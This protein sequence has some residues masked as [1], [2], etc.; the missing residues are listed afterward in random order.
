MEVWMCGIIN[1]LNFEIL[2]T[3]LC[4]MQQLGSG[5]ASK[6]YIQT[7]PNGQ[8]EIVK[9]ISKQHNTKFDEL[10]SKLSNCT[11]IINPESITSSKTHHILKRPYIHTNLYDR[12]STRPFLDADEKLWISY[13]LIYAMS[14]VHELDVIHGDLKLENILV[15]SW[16]WVLISDFA[17]FK[18]CL[19]PDDDPYTFSQLFDTAFR[20]CCNVAPER[21][22]DF[23]DL[24]NST[25][26]QQMDIFSIGCIL[27]E[28]H[29]EQPLFSYSQLILYKN[30]NYDPLPLL[31]SLSIELKSM[32]ANMISLDP[33]NRNTLQ[34]VLLKYKTTFPN[35]FYT[36]F[37]SYCDSLNQ[38]D[39]HH[40]LNWS[41]DYP[42]ILDQLLVGN[43]LPWLGDIKIVKLFTDVDQIVF[44]DEVDLQLKSHLYANLLLSWIRNCTTKYA[45]T[46]SLLLVDKLLPFL[47]NSFKLKRLLPFYVYFLKHPNSYFNALS[48]HFLSNALSVDAI[49]PNEANLFLSYL[50]NPIS[51]L[52]K[53]GTD[54][55]KAMLSKSLGKLAK[56][57]RDHIDMIDDQLFTLDAHFSFDASLSDLHEAFQDIFLNLITHVRYN[58]K[59]AL[60][61]YSFSSLIEFFGKTIT[62][63]LLIAHL[64]TFISHEDYQVKSALQHSVISL[65]EYL[66]DPLLTTILTSGMSDVHPLVVKNC[67]LAATYIMSTLN[68][69]YLL[70]LI[71][72]ASIYLIHPRLKSIAFKFIFK[73]LNSISSADALVVL[74]TTIKPFT[75]V[76]LFEITYLEDMIVPPVNFQKITPYLK[77]ISVA[78]KSNNNLN[79]VFTPLDDLTQPLLQHMPSLYAAVLLLNHHPFI[80]SILNNHDPYE[81]L[82]HLKHIT[83]LLN[84]DLMALLNDLK[85]EW[86]F[87]HVMKTSDSLHVSLLPFLPMNPQYT[88]FNKHVKSYTILKY[89]EQQHQAPI[90]SKAKLSLSINNKL[91]GIKIGKLLE[92]N[93]SVNCIASS[94]EWFASSSSDGSIK[95][96]DTKRLERN[97]SNQSKSTIQIGGNIENLKL[98]RS[99]YLASSNNSCIQVHDV[100]TL[101]PISRID[102][103]GCIALDSN[104]STIGY[105]TTM[106]IINIV[107]TRQFSPI[108]INIPASY[109]LLT[110]ITM[111]S[112]LTSVGTSRGNIL[113]YDIRFMKEQSGFCIPTKQRI[114]T[115]TLDSNNMLISTS[116]SGE[117]SRWDLLNC[118]CGL[119]ASDEPVVDC[120]RLPIVGKDDYIRSP[121]LEQDYRGISSVLVL[122]DGIVCGC[123]DGTARMILENPSLNDMEEYLDVF[124]GKYKYKLPVV[125]YMGNASRLHDDAINGIGYT[126]MPYP[127]MVTGSQDGSIVLWK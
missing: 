3:P 121:I 83:L 11:N 122:E 47:S 46:L 39:F 51:T 99:N 50:L 127:I 77:Y 117:I 73:A 27:A 17:I 36:Q 9:M 53:T 22:I 28:I 29:L 10:K 67:L 93:G 78:N 42:S 81:M 43:T 115:L 56:I 70:Q 49:P 13:Q 75:L 54:L 35:F 126:T 5:R 1:L 111:Q 107:D 60:L 40:F 112:H 104:E 24:S 125:Q 58:T 25:C 96:W 69:Q 113:T 57:S 55:V 79:M 100:E 59:V 8:T 98:M 66:M 109:G 86:V 4:L 41:I 48:L 68:R 76:P 108:S 106:S 116:T 64:S 18:P 71:T 119:Y 94:L 103:E 37:H 74:Q 30:N 15:T 95:I 32:I 12:L 84:N 114:T 101:K 85:E 91:K 45:C 105:C 124:N 16:N 72:L 80:P 118:T 20:H 61:N 2:V 97:V 33:N 6:T 82:H 89:Q 52:S 120:N 110:S 102:I 21:F 31:D 14:K 90:T 88:G 19:L 65:N 123:V 87:D 26:S 44:K 38:F 92:H 63:Q 34:S 23:K 7:T 62:D